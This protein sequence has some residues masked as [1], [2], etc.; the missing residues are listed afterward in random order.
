MQYHVGL[1]GVGMAT[2]GLHCICSILP[3]LN[4]AENFVVGT[5]VA[6]KQ[7][8]VDVAPCVTSTVVPTTQHSCTCSCPSSVNQLIV[9]AVC[10]LEADSHSL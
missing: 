8:T 9:R 7:Y 3:V 4:A 6:S 2:K 1:G 10:R 5:H